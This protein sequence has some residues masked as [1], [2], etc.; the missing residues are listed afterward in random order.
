MSFY[1][2]LSATP[3][4]LAHAPNGSPQIHRRLLACKVCGCV[5]GFLAP[6]SAPRPLASS[7]APGALPPLL[8]SLKSILRHRGHCE[9]GWRSVLLGRDPSGLRPF[10]TSRL[11][12]PPYED[13][14]AQAADRTP[15]SALSV[16]RKSH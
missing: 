12:L 13:S 4:P 8:L 1:T 7:F 6:P 15:G 3:V 5:G 16:Q 2:Y 11:D 9:P 14:C 10:Y